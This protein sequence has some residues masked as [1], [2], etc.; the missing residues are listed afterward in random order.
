MVPKRCQVQFPAGRARKGARS[1]FPLGA[2]EIEPGTF[3]SFVTRLTIQSAR[4]QANDACGGSA[5]WQTVSGETLTGRLSLPPGWPPDC[6]GRQ[7]EDCASTPDRRQ[8]RG[9]L[10]AAACG[11]GGPDPLAS[12]S[13]TSPPPDGNSR[14]ATPPGYCRLGT[15]LTGAWH[16]SY[17]PGPRNWTCHLF[18]ARHGELEPV[19]V[20]AI[21]S[22]GLRWG[23]GGRPGGRA[24]GR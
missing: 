19:T 3:F 14:A 7:R 17:E 13:H 24:R 22:A 6:F 23:R 21:R 4:R 11:R 15:P 20:L 2:L 18:P 9:G 10:H 5:D 1:H 8:R 12:P 16:H